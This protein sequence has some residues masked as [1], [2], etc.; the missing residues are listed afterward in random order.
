MATYGL[1]KR[2]STLK[3]YCQKLR[4]SLTLSIKREQP[5][6]TNLFSSVSDM[7]MP[8]VNQFQFEHNLIREREDNQLE[9]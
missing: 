9:E 5:W 2:C 7:Q 4:K 6:V 1:E 8:F 3:Y